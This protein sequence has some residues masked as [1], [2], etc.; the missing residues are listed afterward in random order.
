MKNKAMAENITRRP[1]ERPMPDRC[2][3]RILGHNNIEVPVIFKSWIYDELEKNNDEGPRHRRGA[4][5]RNDGV[6][7]GRSTVTVS[8]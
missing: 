2:V 6:G 5:R 8:L 7:G 1:G 3:I 4:N